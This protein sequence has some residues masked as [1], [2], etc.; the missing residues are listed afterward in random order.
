M[1][2]DDITHIEQTEPRTIAHWKCVLDGYTEL[3][4]ELVRIGTQV[5]T[6]SHGLR[7]E[8]QILP[9]TKVLV[10]RNGKHEFVRYHSCR[11]SHQH[12]SAC[13]GCSPRAS[14]DCGS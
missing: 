11:F 14:G 13:C 4:G 2:D 6:A 3:S 1:T 8:T 5:V 10:L 12:G 7:D 9:A